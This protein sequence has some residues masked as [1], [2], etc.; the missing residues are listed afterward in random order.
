MTGVPKTKYAVTSDG[1]VVA[2]DAEIVWVPSVTLLEAGLSPWMGV[3]LWIADP[4]WGAA[5]RVDITRAIE[6]G[7]ELR[8]LDET[9]RSALTSE[10]V[11]PSTFDRST[12]MRIL[13][14]VT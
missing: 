14:A 4:A 11:Q 12:E 6:A 9:I 1:H 3:P 10:P 5:N 13:S 7:L 2:S 8:A